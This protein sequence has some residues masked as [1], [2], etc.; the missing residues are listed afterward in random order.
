MTTINV[1]H[2]SKQYPLRGNKR[3]LVPAL[4]D[5]T[6]NIKDGEAVSIL[7]P[8]GCGK[9]TLLR[10]IAGLEEPDSGIVLHNDVPLQQIEARQRVMGMVFQDYALMPHWEARRN[11]GFFLRLRQR[12]LEVPERVE[13]VSRIT[14]FGIEELMDRYPRTLSGGEKQR[15]AIARAFARDLY[16][17]LF[18]EPFANL[19]AK[20]RGQARVE[21]RRL[22][23]SFPVTSVFVTHDQM[24]A[25][26]LSER[27]VLMREGR[28]EQIGNYQILRN[29]PAT[30]F[31]A[32]FIGT[33]TINLFAGDIQDA[34]WHGDHFGAV[35][36]PTTARNGMDVLMGLRADA[37]HLAPEG[38]KVRIVEITHFFAERQSVI[39]VALDNM[40]FQML[41]TLEKG[42]ALQ[43]GDEIHAQLDTQQALFFD[44]V[45]EERLP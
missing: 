43:I 5:V 22:L 23:D 42:Q 7:G 1:E 32:Q 45:S 19:D 4:R 6:L 36:A 3:E 35:P 20:F 2:V 8:S 30:V 33:P 13:L 34:Q 31:A 12:E 21:L 11:V 9:T 24:E 29:D 16:L 28:I 26:S 27:I 18:D 40:P 37:I 10:V 15:V 17:L 39:D 14:G 41:V 44:A 25:A 38:L